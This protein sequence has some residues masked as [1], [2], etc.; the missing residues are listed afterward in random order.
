MLVKNTNI[1]EKV[2]PNEPGLA[3][4]GYLKNVC[5]QLKPN[6]VLKVEG[7]NKKLNY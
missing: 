3:L 2:T 7:K 5:R 6:I 4:S 1:G